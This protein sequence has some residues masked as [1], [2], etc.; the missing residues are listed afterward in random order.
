MIC[1]DKIEFYAGEE[2]LIE[3]V[4]RPANPREIAVVTAARYE[5]SEQYDGKKVESGSCEIDG[6]K[7]SALLKM[8][9]A[10]SYKL[11][12]IAAVGRET[13]IETAAVIVRE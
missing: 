12:I 13:Y 11:K 1:A 4:I 5:L 8:Q 2:R 7:I 6:A 9:K 10:G 3:A